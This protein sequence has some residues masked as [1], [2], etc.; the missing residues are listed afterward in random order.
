[1]KPNAPKHSALARA[2]P[3]LIKALL[4]PALVFALANQSTH[5]GS[6][7][8]NLNPTSGDW[9]TAANW[10]PATVPDDPSDTATFDVSNITAISQQGVI[11]VAEI[12]FNRGASAF[13]ISA[14]GTL[15]IFGAGTTNNSGVV[16]NF[17][18]PGL[19]ASI[20]FYNSATAGKHTVF[21]QQGPV[22]V[23]VTQIAFH[24]NSS[25][26]RATFINEGNAQAGSGTRFYD[27]ATAANG[28]FINK[29]GYSGSFNGGTTEFF[30][31]ASAGSAKFIVE[32]GAP[33]GWEGIL[34]FFDSSTAA[35][36][37]IMLNGSSD[38]TISPGLLYFSDGTS[39]ANA[40]VV[41]NG[42]TVPGASG[43]EIWFDFLD[44]QG[45]PSAGNAS[46]IINGGT[47]GGF[48]GKLAFNYGSLGGTAQVK[49]FDNATLDL[50]GHDP[51]TVSLGA[52][53]GTG[54]VLLGHTNLIVGTTNFSTTFAGNISGP[55]SLIKA[56]SGNFALFSSNAYHGG[57]VV[58]GT[59]FLFV[60]NLTG[61]GTGTGPVQVNSGGLAGNGSISG[62][63][64]VG[65]GSAGAA[66]F[67]P[68]KNDR[69]P[70][71]L[72]I[73]QALTFN[74]D[75]TYLWLLDTVRAI[76]SSVVT[77]SVTIDSAALFSPAEL[78]SGTLHPGTVF[79]VINNNGTAAIV[80]SFSNLP[81][82]SRIT[83]GSNTYQA[84]YEGGDGND[85]TL[86]VQ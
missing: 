47:N 33:S 59:G 66:R 52:I 83:V 17:V 22:S 12:I 11:D 27:S 43:G 84:S 56:G 8:W 73:G 26:G 76:A 63:M 82:G 78:Q 45:A 15:N 5:A 80:G 65:D 25:A 40:T 48:G 31:T 60:N 20:H 16:Q 32:G 38:N 34:Y 13:T 14:P 4:L 51:G 68:G 41:A 18:A 28:V 49:L 42:G 30:N 24:D 29:T 79:T 19:G 36:A 7:T 85:L 55:A 10:T 35:N 57:T 71:V 23:D 86:T 77:S 81:D 44:D 9:N 74:A 6:A 39:A 46:F 21:T 72:T 58:Q 62:A 64:V 1:M 75:A 2:F 67:R 61:S 3:L 70:G 53:A 54:V 69:S 50:S 37:T